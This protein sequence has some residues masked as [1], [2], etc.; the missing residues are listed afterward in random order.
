MMLANP[1]RNYSSHNHCF[2]AGEM[3]TSDDCKIPVVMVF[4]LM[5]VHFPVL[6]HNMEK[7]RNSSLFNSDAAAALISTTDNL[8]STS[9]LS[10]DPLLDSH[11]KGTETPSLDPFLNIENGDSDANGD[12][13]TTPAKRIKTEG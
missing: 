13:Y 3:L 2:S 12:E 1:S 6:V 8:L 11:I 9:P 4:L 7:T 10:T 5:C